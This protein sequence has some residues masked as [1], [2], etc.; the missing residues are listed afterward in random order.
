MPFDARADLDSKSGSGSKRPTW[1]QK[2]KEGNVIIRKAEVMELGRDL[3][4][5]KVFLDPIFCFVFQLF[6]TINY[7]KICHRS[8]PH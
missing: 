5:Y 7:K 1:H 3:N 2:E 6:N 4:K 8:V